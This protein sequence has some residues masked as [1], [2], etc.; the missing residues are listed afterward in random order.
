[1]ITCAAGILG[2]VLGSEIA[3]RYVRFSSPRQ[4]RWFGWQFDIRSLALKYFYQPEGGD[5]NRTEG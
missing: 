1:M 3:R 2:V 5:T 4:T